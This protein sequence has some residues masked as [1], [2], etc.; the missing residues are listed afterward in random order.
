VWRQEW[1]EI[2]FSGSVVTRGGLLFTG[3][4][5]GRLTALDKATGEKLWEFMTDAGGNTTV[6]T[7]LHKGRQL[8]AGGGAF[9]GGK[10]GDGVWAFALDGTLPSLAPAVQAGPGPG[11]GPPA[12]APPSPESSRPPDLAA[13][14]GL[15]KQG[16]VFCH[17]AE[18]S[19]GQGGGPSLLAFPA[20]YIAATAAS[21]KGTAMPAFRA[22]YTPDQLRNIAGYIST[23][24][25][26]RKN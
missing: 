4:A 5:D 17:G 13:G 14:E 9:S 12:A 11:G 24:L 6:T 19:G 18:G 22:V 26:A 23:T 2:C 1:R 20:A 25:A 10:R 16:C 8:H 3:R 21:G 15:Y 7:F